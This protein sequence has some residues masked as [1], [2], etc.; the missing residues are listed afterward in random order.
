MD[1]NAIYVEMIAGGGSAKSSVYEA[2]DACISGDNARAQA[3]LLEADGW[4]DRAHKAQA[5]VLQLWAATLSEDTGQPGS[6]GAGGSASLDFSSPLLMHAQ[7]L[8]M[9]AM[10]ERALAERIIKLAT[11]LPAADR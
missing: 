4:L 2:L 11:R 9:T 5:E 10:S 1:M 3:C 6:S 7:D 8:I